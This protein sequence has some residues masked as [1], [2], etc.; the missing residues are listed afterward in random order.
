MTAIQTAAKIEQDLARLSNIGDTKVTTITEQI[1][2]HENGYSNAVFEGED[3]KACQHEGALKVLYLF[4]AG[5]ITLSAT[6]KVE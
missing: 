2:L 4:K 5:M 6:E 1:T 3:D